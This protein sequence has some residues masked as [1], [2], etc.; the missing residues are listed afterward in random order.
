MSFSQSAGIG[1]IPTLS[2]I[3]LCLAFA[4]VGYNKVT[5]QVEFNAEQAA[6]LQG[7]GVSVSPAEGT[8]VG[9]EAPA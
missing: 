7:L 5:R 6:T 2:R 3:V 9:R 4:S 1:L 8:V